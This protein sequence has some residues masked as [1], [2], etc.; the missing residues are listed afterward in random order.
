MA[1][2]AICDTGDGRASVRT[3][4]IVG[5]IA[6]TTEYWEEAQADGTRETGCRVQLRLVR[7]VPAPIPPPVPRRDA[8]V[9]QVEEP[10]WRADLFTEVGGRGPYDA[11]HYHP[12]FDRLT[13]CERVS[14]D[15]IEADPLGWIMGR[16]ADLP[17]MLAESGHAEL[18]GGLDAGLVRQAMPAVRAN[19]EATLAYRPADPPT[20]D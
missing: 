5:E 16:L 13:P 2:H 8:V 10:I 3:A 15:S 4:V 18:I 6:V 20:V 1:A 7:T 9:W 12:T 14:D 19:I 17:A 11:A